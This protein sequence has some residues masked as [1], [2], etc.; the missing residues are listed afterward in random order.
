VPDFQAERVQHLPTRLTPAGFN[1]VDKLHR[2]IRSFSKVFL[3][4][5]GLAFGPEKSPYI[6][7]IHVWNVSTM[8]LKIKMLILM[9]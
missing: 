4:A 8:L 6:I 7:C 3:A 9:Y 5:H 1:G 2:H